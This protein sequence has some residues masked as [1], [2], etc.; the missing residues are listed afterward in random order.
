MLQ[1]HARSYHQGRHILSSAEHSQA[2]QELSS[3]GYRVS[4][5]EK[6]R[7]PPG[8]KPVDG[9]EV[10]SGYCCPLLKDG[11]RCSRAFLAQ[12]TFVRHLSDHSD[13]LKPKPLSCI[14]D[15]QTLF[16]Q[17][18]LQHYF[19]VNRSL[20]NLDPSSTSAYA[21]AVKMLESLPKAQ[22]PISDHDKDRA[23]IHWFTRWPELLKP[24]MPDRR[25]QESLQSLVSFPEP[26]SDPDWLMRL[27]DHGCRWWKIAE[28]AHAK[29][30]Y[31]ASVMLK[32][33]Q[34]YVPSLFPILIAKP[35]LL[36]YSGPWKV[37]REPESARRY[38][39][40]AIS[41][42]SFCLK[43]SSLPSDKIPTQFT[44]SQRTTLREYQEC[45]MGNPAQSD[46]DTEKFQAAL[47]SV[48]FRDRGFEIDTV[49]RLAC[50][51]QT[52]IALLSLRKTGEFVKP[53]LVTQP[54]SRF[55]YLSRSA[56][57]QTVLRDHNRDTEGFIR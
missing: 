56:V 25:S 20:S 40:T 10:L 18:G 54:I 38:C 5:G 27:R 29:C 32:S 52:Y 16:S 51:L 37:L 7:Q 39:G 47:S 44:E 55:M 31:R 49:G 23:S 12:S 46:S 48:L 22:I 6:Y 19:S 43:A 3:L 36:R 45:L 34:R 57:L 33:H 24:Y 30:S 2:V 14:S 21:Y 15:V 4:N 28:L 42:L 11:I 26:G 13:H 35:P 53:G 17:G 41:F 9:L 1:T 50:P 8:Q